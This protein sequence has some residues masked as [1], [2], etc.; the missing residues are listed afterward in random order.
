MENEMA[1][2]GFLI[3]LHFI[4]CTQDTTLNVA[5]REA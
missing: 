5:S 1:S 3:I 4:V 2:G